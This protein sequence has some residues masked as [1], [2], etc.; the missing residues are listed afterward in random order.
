MHL[1]DRKLLRRVAV[2]YVSPF[3]RLSI[4]IDNFNDN[5]LGSWMYCHFANLQT[6]DFIKIALQPRAGI[7]QAKFI[8][9]ELPEM[10]F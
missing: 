4:F 3:T 7:G 9:G 10:S 2:S 5:R 8:L 1:T 6:V